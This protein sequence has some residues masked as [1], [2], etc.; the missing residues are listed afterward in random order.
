ME[1]KKCVNC[2]VFITTDDNLCTSCANKVSYD[3]TLLKNYL[4]ENTGYNSIVVFSEATG[5][6][7][8]TIQ[9]YLNENSEIGI[10]INNDNSDL[11]NHIPY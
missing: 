11:F 5:I 2:G 4:N 7:P 3:K 9:N 1:V 6:D 8:H 10:S